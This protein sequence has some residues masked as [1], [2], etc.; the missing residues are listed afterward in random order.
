MTWMS[1]ATSA[2]SVPG[3]RA[4]H[5]SASATEVSDCLGSMTMVLTPCSCL[6]FWV[7]KVSPP[8][9]M[10]VSSGLLPNMTWSLEFATSSKEFE[11]THSP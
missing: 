7:T 5:S 11:P 2:A 1:P 9:D 3:R 4:T 10:R 6:I 8:P